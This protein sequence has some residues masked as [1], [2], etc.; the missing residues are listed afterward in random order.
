MNEKDRHYPIL[1][2]QNRLRGCFLTTD[3]VRLRELAAERDM[4]HLDNLCRGHLPVSG[5]RREI[6]RKSRVESDISKMPQYRFLLGKLMS[7]VA[8]A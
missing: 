6:P 1:L 8:V 4:H 3:R 7:H 2:S 5:R